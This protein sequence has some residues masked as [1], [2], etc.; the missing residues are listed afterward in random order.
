M[1]YADTARRKRRRRKRSTL[2]AEL[3]DRARKARANNLDTLTELQSSQPDARAPDAR[4]QPATGPI[5][6]IGRYCVVKV[7]GDTPC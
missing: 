1:V 3:G 5:S 7:A 2:D 6:S 4:P